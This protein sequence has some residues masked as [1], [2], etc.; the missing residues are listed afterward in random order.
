MRIERAARKIAA[1][2]FNRGNFSPAVVDLEHQ[3]FGF[4]LV[5]D[6]YFAKRDSA[7][8]QKLLG[9]AA[10]AATCGGVNRYFNHIRCFPEATSADATTRLRL[11]Y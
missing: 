6:V 8:R 9:S 5:V 3:F 4:G 2:Y 11:T 10:I 7:L 1:L